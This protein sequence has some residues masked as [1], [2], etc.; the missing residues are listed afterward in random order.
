MGQQ[1][2]SQAY[3]LGISDGRLLLKRFRADGIADLDTFKAALTNCEELLG[4][5]FASDMRDC[6]RGER[7]FW[8]NQ[9]KRLTQGE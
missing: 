5:G 6:L 2:V 4:Q 9:V 7:D 3:L 1:T 8:R